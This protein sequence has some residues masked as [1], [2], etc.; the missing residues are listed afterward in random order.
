[1]RRCIGFALV[2]LLLSVGVVNALSLPEVYTLQ[3]SGEDTN[4][5]GFTTIS[6]YVAQLEG[7]YMSRTDTL[8]GGSLR[9][10]VFLSSESIFCCRSLARFAHLPITPK[11]VIAP[12][13]MKIVVKCRFLDV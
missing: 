7:N 2:A 11:H 13:L 6:Y 8:D 10:C 4:S 12:L 5:V 9:C 3:L 1:M